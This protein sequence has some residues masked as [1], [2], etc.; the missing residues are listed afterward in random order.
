MTVI[1]GM[2]PH[3][4]SATIEAID[5]TG[6]ILATGR[7]ATDTAG[8]TD[9]LTAAQQ[10]TKR[11]WAVEGCNGIGRHLAHRLVHDGETVIDVPA[12]LSAQV[13]VFA[14]GN[15][16]KTDPVDAHSVALAALHAP[17]L[18]R[19]TADPELVA[20]GMLAD[21]RDE[22]GRARTETLCRLHR[23]LLELIPGGAKQFLSARQARELAVTVTPSDAAARVR[24]RL[25]MEMIEDLETIDRKTRAADKE[26]CQL[27]AD[28]GSTLMELHGI[29]P[30]SA[31]RL[32]ADAGDVH[33][34][35]D[36]D[37]FA[38]WNGTAPLDASSGDQQRHRLS[39]AGNRKINR[40]L[41][42]MAIVQLR[43]RTTGRVYYDAR[44][45]GGK[46][47]MEALRA[48]KRRLSNVVYARMLADQRRREWAGPGGQS[49]TATD[50]SATG[51]NPHT[52]PS[53]KPHPG[54]AIQANPASTPTP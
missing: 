20:L 25:I 9:M 5:P 4:R 7:Y 37:R 43:N 14:T 13:R 41:H 30:S 1:I 48:L 33:R 2:D 34:F 19:V 6:R 52:D 27:V 8:Y 50:S 23:L 36:R 39:R 24:L 45:A 10:F 49:G 26:L 3:K 17:N 28:R 31:A 38:S 29:G 53:D 40:V 15:G 44:K 32:L 18:R 16:R 54:P 46:T 11:V 42:I 47:S 51:S 22:L 21:R 12:K 35:R